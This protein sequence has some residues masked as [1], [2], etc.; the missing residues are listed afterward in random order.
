VYDSSG[1]LVLLSHVS[2]DSLRLS[3]L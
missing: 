1:R 2:L 3:I